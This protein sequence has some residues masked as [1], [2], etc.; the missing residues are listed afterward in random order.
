M[1]RL[2]SA[3]E[4]GTT[5]Y[6]GFT[7][8]IRNKEIFLVSDKA[9]LTDKIVRDFINTVCDMKN[10]GDSIRNSALYDTATLKDFKYRIQ[11]ATCSHIVTDKVDYYTIQGKN[12]TESF[13]SD[14]FKTSVIFKYARE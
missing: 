5:T 1:K 3:S 14:E 9:Y 4:E 13:P 8:N 6:K 2:I 7:M 12:F 10:V 11:K